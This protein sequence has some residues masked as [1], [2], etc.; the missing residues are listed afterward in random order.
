MQSK[1]ESEEGYKV[2]MLAHVCVC[3]CVDIHTDTHTHIRKTLKIL[4]NAI[5]SKQQN[6]NLVKEL[7]L[8]T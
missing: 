5:P 2:G 6:L 4:D 8:S 3:V 1:D 7:L